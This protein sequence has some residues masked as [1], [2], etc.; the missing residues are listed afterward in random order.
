[1]DKVLEFF[2][3]VVERLS[4]SFIA[5]DIDIL[6]FQVSFRTMLRRLYTTM[7]IAGTGGQKPTDISP[8]KYLQM[9]NVLRSQYRFLER[10]MRKVATGELSEDQIIARAFMYVQASEQM[11][12]RGQT[13]VQLPAY[14]RDGSSECLM[15]CGCSWE[16]D[17]QTNVVLATWVLGPTEHCSTCEQRAAMWNPLV[18]PLGV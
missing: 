6:D 8:A 14:P 16:L 10:F 2:L 15:H 12:W 4:R 3:K 11:Y 13:D 7:L 9:A 1:M 18:I 17:Y 5:G